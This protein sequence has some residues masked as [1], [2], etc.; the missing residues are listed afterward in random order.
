MYE[1]IK[2][3][4]RCYYIQS[5]AKI[6]IYKI[7]DDEVCLIDSGNDKDA[8]KKV[9]KIIT[10]QG[11]RLSAI[12]NT[13][14]HADH[15]GGNGYLQAQTGCKIY[16]KGI[17]ADFTNHPILESA[18]L[19]GGCPMEELKHK[20]LLAK[21]SV[22]ES[23]TEDKLPSGLR[24][25]DLSGHSF[26][27]VGFADEEGTFFIADSLSSRE[28]LDKYRIGFIYDVGAYLE[29]LENIKKME[30]KMFVPSHAEPCEDISGLA[31]YNID[32]VNEV[33]EKI[34][35][36]CAEPICFEELLQKLFDEYSLVMT[37]EQY[38]LVGSTV[39][40]YLTYLKKTD[41]ISSEIKD[42]KLLWISK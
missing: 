22:C 34:V 30:A 18:F 32:K 4:E 13:H 14:S 11:W 25:I 41:K 20:F 2:V 42:S 37:N 21:E 3:S 38:V 5:P 17:E 23:I 27:M 19:Y 35:S 16:A 24:M 39:R 28:T 9:L 7:S 6:G 15:I 33:A 29:T 31:Q 8:G 10:E 36:L 40:S 26:D 12:Y 1:L